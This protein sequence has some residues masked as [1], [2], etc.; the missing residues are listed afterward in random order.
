MVRVPPVNA[1]VVSLISTP[2][3]A[4]AGNE[5]C[6]LYRVSA[7]LMVHV[8]VAICVSVGEASVPKVSAEVVA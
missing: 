5:I 8:P 6:A 3:A 2:L 1:P 4:P 7:P